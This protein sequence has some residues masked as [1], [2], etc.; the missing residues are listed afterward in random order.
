M[1]AVQAERGACSTRAKDVSRT[2][3]VGRGGGGVL[4]RDTLCKPAT[5]GT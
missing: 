3:R 5:L 2:K 1:G 4:E